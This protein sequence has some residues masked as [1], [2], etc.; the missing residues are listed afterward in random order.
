MSCQAIG[1]KLNDSRK[2]LGHEVMTH[3]K[4]FM[5]GVVALAAIITLGVFIAQG[6]PLS[7][8]VNRA[9]IA[10]VTT[11]T[12]GLSAAAVIGWKRG[13]KQNETES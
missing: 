5:V 2:G 3:P 8:A 7:G 6:A 11:A 12:I 4:S 1:Q 9:L 10:G 13:T